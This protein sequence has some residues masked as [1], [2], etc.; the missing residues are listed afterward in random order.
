[1]SKRSTRGQLIEL[2]GEPRINFLPGEIQER[3][4]A[5]RRRRSLFMLVILVGVLCGLGYF[6]S[7]QY[8]T[9]RRAALEA[10]QQTTL[11]LLAQQGQFAEARTFANQ[12]NTIGKAIAHVSRNETPWRELVVQLRDALPAGV[13]L[14]Q[15]S[16]GGPTSQQVAELP[17]EVFTNEEEVGAIVVIDV[18]ASSL[19]TLGDAITRL[20]ALPGVLAAGAPSATLLEDGRGY[21]AL[22]GVVFTNEVYS[23]RFSDG[24]VPGMTPITEPSPVPME[25]PSANDDEEDPT[26]AEEGQQ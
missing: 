18:V 10:E 8:A 14:Q 21:G 25:V 12:V 5:R 9:E 19:A 6:Y 22:I 1:M 26:E 17:D 24:W 2:G 4:D 20:Q 15:W 23:G 13:E 3:K 16:L 7:A 11:D